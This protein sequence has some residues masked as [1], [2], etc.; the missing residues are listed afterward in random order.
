V[1][2]CVCV[3]VSVCMGVWVCGCVGVWRACTCVC[4]CVGGETHSF[5]TPG[6]GTHSQ[7]LSNSQ[8]SQMISKRMATTRSNGCTAHPTALH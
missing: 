6:R 2:V 7:M 1:C 3:C 4:V 8:G 5:F